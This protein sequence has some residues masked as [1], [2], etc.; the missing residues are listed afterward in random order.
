MK[1]GEKIRTIFPKEKD[2]PEGCSLKPP[3]KQDVCLVNGALRHW[4]GP[5]QEVLSPVCV[6]E[7]SHLVQ[8]IIGDYPLLTE[9]ESLNV[10][11]AAVSAYNHGRGAWPTMS[12]GDRIDHVQE[13][14]YRMKEK[15]DEV[16]NLLMWEV[17]KSLKDSEKEFDRTIEYMKS[18]FWPLSV[19]VL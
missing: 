9:R 11:N 7:S 17:G 19:P 3:I 13:F 2:I 16:V 1:I 12:V 4:D 6:W 18:T 14:V 15:R 10:L 5:T 8:K